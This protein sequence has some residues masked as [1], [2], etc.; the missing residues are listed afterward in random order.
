MFTECFVLPTLESKEE[1]IE[2]CFSIFYHDI[3]Y[4]PRSK[5][6]EEDSVVVWKQYA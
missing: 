3:I 6:N 4:D 5:T 1:E 2:L